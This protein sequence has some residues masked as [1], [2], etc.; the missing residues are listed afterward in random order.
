ITDSSSSSLVL[1]NQAK[2]N[3]LWI[4][5]PSCRSS[6]ILHQRLRTTHLPHSSKPVGKQATLLL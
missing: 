3:R 5:Y 1:Y 2:E 4:C 6:Y